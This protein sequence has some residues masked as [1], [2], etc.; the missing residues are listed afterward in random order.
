MSFWS[1]LMGD[2]AADASRAA[3]GDTY[4][5]QTNAA[6]QT[7]D[8]QQDAIGKL[9]GYGTE[10][11]QQLQGL[12]GA[13]D[14]YT[15]T[16]GIANEQ[17]Q[18]LL[19]DPSSLRHLPG[20]QFA[21]DQG[22]QAL[23]RSAKARGMLESG[24][25]DKDLLRF[26]T[27]LADQTYGNQLSRLMGLTQMGIGA[28]GAKNATAGQGYQGM[29][30]ARQSAYGGD[31]GSAA[32]RGG[33]LYGSSPTIGQGDIA[34]ANAQASGVQNLLGVGAFLGGKIAGGGLGDSFGKWLSPAKA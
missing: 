5:K 2:D 19:S 34:A 7:Y 8:A 13:Y 24:R 26:S 21:Q 6:N 29:L 4:S 22:I 14:P 27:G 31:Y 20:Y 11:A 3:A 25:Q 33:M 30:G 1:A 23:D 12:S 32:T 18:K 9:L 16:G 15:R 28:T 10:Y 17:L